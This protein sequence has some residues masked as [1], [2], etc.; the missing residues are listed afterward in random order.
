MYKIFCS[1]KSSCKGKDTGINIKNRELY[2]SLL[3]GFFLFKVKT[4]KI[5]T[6]RGFNNFAT[7]CMYLKDNEILYNGAQYIFQIQSI[8]YKYTYSICI[9]MGAGRLFEYSNSL[10]TD[11]NV[12]VNLITV[13]MIA[14]CELQIY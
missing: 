9:G 2:F 11:K 1:F 13:I 5:I 7:S 4:K 8:S 10:T 12:D 3:F 6:S 14:C